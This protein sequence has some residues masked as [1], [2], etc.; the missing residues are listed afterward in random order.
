[1]TLG[2]NVIAALKTCRHINLLDILPLSSL[3]TAGNN[4]VAEPLVVTV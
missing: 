1:M 3:T 4:A 2:Y